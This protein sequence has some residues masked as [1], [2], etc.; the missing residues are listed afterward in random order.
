M[1]TKT[2]KNIKT[3]NLKECF[4]KFDSFCL[5]IRQVVNPQ[6]G[7]IKNIISLYIYIV[8]Y[9]NEKWNKKK[10][11]QRKKNNQQNQHQQTTKTPAKTLRRNERSESLALNKHKH[12]HTRQ[13]C[14][15]VK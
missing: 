15:Y 3:A 2:N 1:S 10:R 14:H 7:Q 5:F 13:N 11:H 6:T 9:A 4:H 8:I 12:T